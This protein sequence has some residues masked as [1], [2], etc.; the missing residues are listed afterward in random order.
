MTGVDMSKRIGIVIQRYGL[1]IVGGSEYLC[2]QIAERLAKNYQ[3]DVLT[4]CAKDYITWANEYSAG[5]SRVNGVNIIRFPNEKE[6]DLSEFNK[7]SEW[8]YNNSH[9]REDELKWLEMQGPACPELIK[10]IREQSSNYNIMIFF[11]YLYYSTY[12]GIKECQSKIIL[13]PT[14]HNEP[15]IKLDIYKEIFAKANAIIFNTSSE[16]N[17]ADNLF[18]LDNKIILVI[19]TG[20]RIPSKLDKRIFKKK[21][22]LSKDYIVY[23]GRINAG[24]GCDELINY[25][26]KY[27]MRNFDYPYLILFGKLEME[28]PATTDVIYLGF[29]SEQ[30]KDEVYAG[31]RL[32]VV[33]SAYESLS[34]ILLEGF[35]CGVPALVNSASPVLVDHCIQ[36]KAGL[37]YSNYDEFEYMLTLLLQDNQLRNI[38]SKNALKYVKNN[39]NWA[40][41]IN[42]FTA[43][44]EQIA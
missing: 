30:E 21:N 38:M 18:D 32:L 37:Y 11:T 25:Y 7:Y 35:A 29:I 40:K 20:V 4:T 15:A 27:K 8:I 44:I 23:G 28:L 13:V 41:V 10:Y 17:L 24:K 3:V 5:K 9:N 34:L 33:P 19:G 42:E 2:R 43:L 22:G 16:R 36:S 12:Y 6:R 31:A 14:V 26:L 1:D 39:F